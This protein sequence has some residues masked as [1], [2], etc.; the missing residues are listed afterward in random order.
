[1]KKRA[2]EAGPQEGIETMGGK[3][4]AVRWEGGRVA[5]I[6]GQVVA[7]Y[8]M[9]NKKLAQFHAERE[10]ALEVFVLPNG[11]NYVIDT[12]KKG[13]SQPPPSS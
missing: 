5:E 3:T 13:E 10:E 4:Y 6:Y 12:A 1:M 7:S 9:I 8:P 11:H 2:R